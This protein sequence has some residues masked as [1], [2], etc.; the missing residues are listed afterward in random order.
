[1]GLSPPVVVQETKVKKLE[2]WIRREIAGRFMSTEVSSDQ[3]SK[4]R[5][6]VKLVSNDAFMEGLE[7][8][9]E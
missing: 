8:D 3:G 5:S 4:S 1:M 6:A 2:N 9:L 7:G